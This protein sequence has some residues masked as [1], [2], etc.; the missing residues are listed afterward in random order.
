MNTN[1]QE[2]LNLP[3]VGLIISIT[4][5][6]IG[7]VVCKKFRITCMNPLLI[8]IILTILIIVLTPLSVENYR[9]G[10]TMLTFFIL[11]ATT[12]F[13]IT[14]YKQRT[15][16]VRN[17]IPVL[18]GCIAGSATSIFSVKLLC[19]FFALDSVLTSSLLPKSVTTAIALE[20]T[21]K[22]GGIPSITIIAISITGIGTS[23]IGPLLIKY[24]KLNDKV[25]AGCAMGMAGHAIGTARAVQLGDIEGGM[26]GIALCFA[27]IITSLLFLVI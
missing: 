24:L 2:L 8:G 12:V 25:A 26:A 1:F 11:P 18:S 27:G 7:V 22:Y 23:M 4:T 21:E 13:A 5:Y 20:L 14:M 15:V 10:G 17:L 9:S 19:K 16:L 3:L 6:G